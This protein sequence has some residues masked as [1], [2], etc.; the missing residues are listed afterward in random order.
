MSSSRRADI[1]STS[2]NGASAARIIWPLR[3][4]SRSSQ[5]R[6]VPSVAVQLR[7]H[8]IV[9]ERIRVAALGKHVVMAAKSFR[10]FIELVDIGQDADR[11]GFGVF[12]DPV[13]IPA[14]EDAVL[15]QRI[16]AA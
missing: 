12:L 9:T 8:E 16:K 5:K 13:L 3:A 15:S 14:R 2:G 10:A 6:T 7:E 11:R 4:G 1:D